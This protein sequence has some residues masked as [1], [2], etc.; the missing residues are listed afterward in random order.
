M[1]I[2]ERAVH[3]FGEVRQVAQAI[4]ELAELIVALRHYDRGR[5][6][7]DFVAGEIADVEII[8]RQLREIIGSELVDQ[9]RKRKEA[10]LAQ[11]LDEAA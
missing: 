10:R 5:C 8:C 4:E 1:S 9:A 7:R 6:S 2:Y 11:L 3:V